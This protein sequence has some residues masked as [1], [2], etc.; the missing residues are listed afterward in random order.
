MCTRHGQRSDEHGDASQQ[1]NSA[2]QREESPQQDKSVLVKYQHQQP[3]GK[4]YCPRQLAHVKGP[5]Y[6]RHVV[7]EY[8]GQRW[9]FLHVGHAIVNNHHDEGGDPRD[10]EEIGEA[11]EGLPDLRRQ[12][13]RVTVFRQGCRVDVVVVLQR[14]VIVVGTHV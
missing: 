9:I 13:R 14:A 7:Q 1:E 6:V 5:W 12:V 2:R 4:Q 8:I 11:D 3:N 10:D